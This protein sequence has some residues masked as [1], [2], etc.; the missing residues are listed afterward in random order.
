MCLSHHTDIIFV[1]TKNSPVP[2]YFAWCRLTVL[3]TNHQIIL[4]EEPVVSGNL[5][6]QSCVVI[7]IT[8]NLITSKLVRY[9]HYIADG[10]TD[11]FFLINSYFFSGCLQIGNQ[12]TPNSFVVHKQSPLGILTPF[13]W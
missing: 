10:G 4:V 11:T 12:N 3:L 7:R 2:R 9:S 13:P 8:L 6:F 5:R 1:N